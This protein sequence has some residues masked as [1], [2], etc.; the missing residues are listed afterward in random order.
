MGRFFLS[1][2]VKLTQNRISLMEVTSVFISMVYLI[3]LW[4]LW[5]S[6]FIACSSRPS[7]IDKSNQS[8]KNA[9][10]NFSQA[11]PAQFPPKKVGNPLSSQETFSISTMVRAVS[12]RLSVLGVKHKMNIEDHEVIILP[13]GSHYLN[14]TAK[15]LGALGGGVLKYNGLYFAKNPFSAGTFL[16]PEEE[17][18]V[19]HKAI[20]KYEILIDVI[21]HELVHVMTYNK[22]KEKV[23]SPFYCQFKGEQFAPHYLSCDEMN[24]Y[25]QD[26][27]RLL[28]TSNKISR[29]SI[30]RS[31]LAAA[32]MH[33]DPIPQ[34]IKGLAANTVRVT[35]NTLIIEGE[36]SS[37]KYTM[38]F[39][40]YAVQ[41]SKLPLMELAEI[42]TRKVQAKAQELSIFFS[43]LPE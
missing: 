42:Y 17:M 22:K 38:E 19:S 39:P 35:G 43:Q 20:K 24:A 23:P 11:F 16:E 31:K 7:L 8:F 33:T 21:E 3:I 36:N 6:T 26:L 4:G 37:G 40:T 34:L 27:K 28:K 41:N 29:A 14:K 9:E 15:T 18:L 2:K 1:D 10:I 32:K 12:G 30:I 13:K 5:G 25:H